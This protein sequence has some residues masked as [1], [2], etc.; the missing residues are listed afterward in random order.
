MILH[1]EYSKEAIDL[2]QECWREGLTIREELT[3][4]QWAQR[5]RWIAQGASP[6]SSHGDI[7]YSF[8]RFPYCLEPT[9]ETINPEVQVSVWMFASGMAKTEMA[10]NVLGYKSEHS[11]TNKFV[12]FPKEES[13]DK[14]SRDVVQR[15]LIDATPCVQKVYVEAKGR[16]AGNTIAYKRHIGGSLYLTSAGSASNFRGPRAGLV[17]C[18]EIDG[19]PDSAGEEGDPI[20]LAFKRA[21]GFEDSIKILEGTPTIKFHSAIENWLNKS[22]K[23][24]WLAP[25]RGCGRRQV[26]MWRERPDITELQATVAWPKLGRNRHE[27]AVILCGHCARAHDDRQR[28]AMVM[29]GEWKP[30]QRF[31]GIRGYWLNGLNTTL[32]AEKGF[33]SKM[34]QFAVDAHNAAHSN[35]RRHTV[36]VWT[37]TFLAET[38]QE[39]QDIKMPWVSLFSRREDYPAVKV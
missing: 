33:K 5:E 4:A 11:P 25:C 38:Y 6:L 10:V 23:R 2:A 22:D 32:P 12:V 19:F 14:F 18:G 34:H 7:R 9:N 8:D 13:R 3:P 30:T 35:N 24:M 1:T 16:E 20:A 15:S 17:Y 31:S 26:L 36:R 37:N 21:E 27:K 39:E 28:I 29:E